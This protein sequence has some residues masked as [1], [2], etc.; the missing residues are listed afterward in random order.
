MAKSQLS[1]AIAEL[2]ANME[3]RT[4]DRIALFIGSP[5]CLSSGPRQLKKPVVLINASFG[6]FLSPLR[7][8]TA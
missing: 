5:L 3:N 6:I 4:I 2:V 1:E 7:S 8:E